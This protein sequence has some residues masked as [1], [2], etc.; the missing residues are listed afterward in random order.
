VDRQYEKTP[1]QQHKHKDGSADNSVTAPAKPAPFR[2]TRRKL[3]FPKAVPLSTNCDSCFPAG[4]LILMA[5]G[6]QKPVE[7]V[8]RGDRV[9]GLSGINNVLGVETPVL[10]TRTMLQM[11]DGS[12]RWSAEHS[13]WTLRDGDQWWGSQYKEQFDRETARGLLGGLQC[14]RPI[15]QMAR[16]GETYAHIDGWKTL[17]AIEVPAAHNTRLYYVRTDGCHTA[18]A[19]GFVVGGGLNDQDFDY[20]RMRWNGL[21]SLRAA[22]AS[23]QRIARTEGE[24]IEG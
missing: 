11:S 1:K 21:A 13:M 8:R 19:D 18:I 2:V 12:L 23:L 17:D 22:V 20:T 10:G 24:L 16:K 5:D 9:W 15:R 3:V 14:S 7:K 6:S 4:T